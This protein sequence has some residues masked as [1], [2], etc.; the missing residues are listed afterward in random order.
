LLPYT[1]L[2]RS[3]GRNDLFDPSTSNGNF[4]KKNR[5]SVYSFL[6]KLCSLFGIGSHDISSNFFLYWFSAKCMGRLYCGDF[7][8]LLEA[9]TFNRCS[10]SIRSGA[11]N[12]VNWILKDGGEI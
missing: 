12:T 11:Y 3:Y 8:C 1:T 9:R 10:W 2:F 5:K 7:A 6:F 4:P